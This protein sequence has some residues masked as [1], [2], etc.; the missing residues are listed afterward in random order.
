[1]ACDEQS[2]SVAHDA[3]AKFYSANK[4]KPCEFV[5]RR[6]NIKDIVDKSLKEH[7]ARIDHERVIGLIDLSSN[8]FLPKGVLICDS[9]A[10]F[11]GHA[12]R[13]SK[14]WY[15]EI[16]GIRVG[17][18]KDGEY[19][20]L[21]IVFDDETE[22][23]W[24]NDDVDC[25]EFANFLSNL[26]DVR[27]ASEPSM[28]FDN[29]GEAPAD[30]IDL[31]DIGGR[32]VGNQG[33]V[34][35]MFDEQRFHGTRGHG[36][37]AERANDLEDRL[38]GKNARIDGDN[39]VLNGPDRS[40]LNA[41]GTT[42]WIQSKY[43]A[44][45]QRCINAC[46]K[47]GNL[48]YLDAAGKPMVI[49]VP[50]DKY[51]EAVKAMARRIENGQIPNVTDPNAAKDIVKPGYFTYDQAKNIA[52]AGNVDSIIYDAK[53]GAVISLSTFGISAAITL[54]VSI[55]NGDEPRVA[56]KHAAFSG[57]KVGGATI[58]T[59]VLASQIAK[60]SINQAMTSAFQALAKAMGPKTTA[61]IVNA[62]R[63][64]ANISGQ[65]AVNSAAKLL[66]GNAISAAVTALVLT[67]FDITDIVRGRISGK[68]L[69]KNMAKTTTTVAGG[70]AGWV[71]GSAVGSVIM[72]GV[73]TVVG[74]LIGSLV[75]GGTLGVAVDKITGHFIGSDEER[76]LKI[77]QDEFL[78]VCEEYLLNQDEAEKASDQLGKCVDGSFLKKMHASKDRE[79]FVRDAIMPDVERIVA[80]RPFVPKPSEHQIEDGFS[81]ALMDIAAYIENEGHG[82]G[83]D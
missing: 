27:T 22:F 7:A 33:A 78:A 36:F 18:S 12:R 1:M 38:R 71:G 75:A 70:T 76:M 51:Q 8:R 54:A 14:I 49:E 61:V 3:F 13:A 69:A 43:C 31:G 4:D 5:V 35:K 73:G 45:G 56:L 19:S 41:D 11:Y 39:N 66:K 48:R 58:L 50:S 21:T 26:K 15:D 80:R 32:A 28:A 82:D 74:G 47:D 77:L 64:G 52:K 55:W 20:N 34:N 46:F 29:L 62:F 25:L 16:D 9:K 59:T 79:K 68:Q 72:P 30:D 60:S 23:R 65:A 6:E 67:S 37:A 81:D 40:I 42:T 83:E 63:N 2:K 53:S 10:Y 17:K 44:T 57:I 24:E